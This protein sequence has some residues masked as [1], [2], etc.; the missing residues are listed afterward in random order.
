MRQYRTTVDGLSCMLLLRN[1]RPDPTLALTRL[2]LDHG[3][4]IKERDEL[5]WTVLHCL[6]K[7]I[8]KNND[9]QDAS[10]L[11]ARLLLDHGADATAQD[12][13]GWTVLQNLAVNFLKNDSHDSTLA[14]ITLL[15]DHGADATV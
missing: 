12:N 6:A 15:L 5:G 1:D 11:L 10:L 3:P 4:D 8:D 9:S 7:N 2:L 13:D 14:L